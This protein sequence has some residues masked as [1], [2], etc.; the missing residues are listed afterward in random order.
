[1]AEHRLVLTDRE[2]LTMNVVS[3]VVRFDEESVV[4]HTEL[5]ILAVQ[6]R[7]LKLR[8]LTPE[9]GQVEVEGLVEALR[10]QEPRVS[11][12]WFHRLLG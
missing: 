3:E 7:E 1:M 4:V 11:G 9:G 8:T 2:R 10:Y 12:G 6:G 5:G